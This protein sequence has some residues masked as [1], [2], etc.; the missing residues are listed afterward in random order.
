MG[1]SGYAGSKSGSSGSS[2]SGSHRHS[3]ILRHLG[4]GSETTEIRQLTSSDVSALATDVTCIATAW[5]N[6]CGHPT[7][8]WFLSPSVHV[9]LHQ[10]LGFNNSPNACLVL[11]KQDCRERTLQ[12]SSCFSA[13]TLMLRAITIIP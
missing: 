5:A 11:L 7:S 13:V 1:L 2:Q 10:A 8:T 12:L 4:S 6:G 3:E 9:S